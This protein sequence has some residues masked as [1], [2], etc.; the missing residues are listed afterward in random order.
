MTLKAKLKIVEEF[1]NGETETTL[2]D[3]VVVAFFG[4][5]FVKTVNCLVIRDWGGLEVVPYTKLNLKGEY[6]GKFE[7]SATGQNQIK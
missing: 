1:E 3:V 6:D 7:P 2:E 4:A 5:D